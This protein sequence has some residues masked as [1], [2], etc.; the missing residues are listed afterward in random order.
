MARAVWAIPYD[1]VAR[2][3]LVR[4]RPVEIEVKLFAIARERVGSATL[5]LSLPEGATVADLRSALAQACPDL[6]GLV[7]QMLIAVNAEYADDLQPLS[8]GAEIACIP[9]VSGGQ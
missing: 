8:P 7:P 5:P 1:N 9:P 6:A 4:V 3:A 2:G